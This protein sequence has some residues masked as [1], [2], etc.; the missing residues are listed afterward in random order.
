[1]EGN[2]DNVA[3]VLLLYGVIINYIYKKNGQQSRKTKH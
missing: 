2:K 3:P 1:M